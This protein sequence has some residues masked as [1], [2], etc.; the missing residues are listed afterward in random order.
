M[1]IRH[2]INSYTFIHF[3][4]EQLSQHLANQTKAELQE[5]LQ[6]SSN[7]DR[8][9][10]DQLPAEFV[11]VEYG[12][13]NISIVSITSISFLNHLILNKPDWRKFLVFKV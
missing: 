12:D 1:T 4:Q 3:F 8:V 6:F 7:I 10:V 13:Q 9:I 2:S 11:S 5:Q